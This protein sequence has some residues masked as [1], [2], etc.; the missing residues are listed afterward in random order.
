M[1]KRVVE[2]NA[3]FQIRFDRQKQR[4]HE[5]VAIGAIDQQTMDRASDQYETMSQGTEGQSHTYEK[6]DQYETMSPCTEEQ[7]HTYEKCE[8]QS[9]QY[10]AQTANKVTET[11]SH[12]PRHTNSES[13]DTVSE[14]NS[15]TRLNQTEITADVGRPKEHFND[16]NEDNVKT[17]DNHYDLYANLKLSDA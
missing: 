7:N 8:R 17:N 2:T 16:A 10:S 11:M 15:E 4:G 5:S 6:C 9:Y 14:D 13:R 1:Q 3:A 12:S